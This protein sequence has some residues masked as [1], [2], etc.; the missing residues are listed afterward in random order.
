MEFILNNIAAYLIV[1]G[2]C[3]F[4]IYWI[5]I[6]TG[7]FINFLI[8]AVM[9]LNVI[10]LIDLVN[11]CATIIPQGGSIFDVDGYAWILIVDVLLYLAPFAL[12]GMLLTKYRLTEIDDLNKKLYFEEKIKENN[13]Y[14]IIYDSNYHVYF[15]NE[16]QIDR[17]IKRIAKQN[18]R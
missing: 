8:F 11:W 13:I 12:Y 9:S 1:I 2:A 3:R 4:A 6:V 7:K 17:A 15:F 18:K 10:M 14:D 16:K 5:G